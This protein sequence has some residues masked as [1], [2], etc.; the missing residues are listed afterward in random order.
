MQTADCIGTSGTTPLAVTG[1]QGGARAGEDDLLDGCP[2]NGHSSGAGKAPS[3]INELRG[4]SKTRRLSGTITGHR[5]CWSKSTSTRSSPPSPLTAG[6]QRAEAQRAETVRARSVRCRRHRRARRRTRGRPHL[7]PTN[8]ASASPS[9]AAAAAKTLPP[10]TAAHAAALPAP[11]E[12]SS[13]PPIGKALEPTLDSRL[14]SQLCTAL[15][16]LLGLLRMHR[17]ASVLL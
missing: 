11:Q 12:M 1:Q 4:C 15:S 17:R 13:A 8:N 2:P 7:R 6:A 14:A 5:W 16:R 9:A 3:L 10:P